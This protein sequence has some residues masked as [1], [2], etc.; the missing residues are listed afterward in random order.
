MSSPI[1]AT[2]QKSA[3]RTFNS[4]LSQHSTGACTCIDGRNEYEC[5]GDTP[6]GLRGKKT[7]PN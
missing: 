5:D 4:D 3:S 1:G 2:L 6:F 7:S